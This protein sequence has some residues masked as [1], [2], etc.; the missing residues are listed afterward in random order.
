M[1]I[2][3]TVNGKEHTLDVKPYHT[4]L[5]VIREQLGLTGTKKGC[6]NGECGACT[7]IMNGQPVRSCLVLGVE[8]DGAEILTIE[9]LGTGATLDPVQQAFI[10][11]A[12]VQCGFCTPG[13]I[14]ATKAL[15]DRQE[16]PDDEAIVQAMSGHLCR[17]TGYEAIMRAVKKAAQLRGLNH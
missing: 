13:F 14:M 11:E 10:D 8:A 6:G 12:A 1:V 17:C 7:I 3:L 2:K 9:G 5:R 16:H 15:L 4:L